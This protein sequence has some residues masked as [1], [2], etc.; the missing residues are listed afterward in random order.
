MA[1]CSRARCATSRSGPAAAICEKLARVL[2]LAR[3]KQLH[4]GFEAASCLRRIQRLGHA[5]AASRVVAD[6][7]GSE[8]LVVWIPVVYSCAYRCSLQQDSFSFPAC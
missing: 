6:R 5:T 8:I 4:G 3:V 7:S 1:I 2:Q